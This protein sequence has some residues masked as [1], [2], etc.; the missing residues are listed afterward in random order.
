VAAVSPRVTCHI[1]TGSWAAMGQCLA[2]QQEAAQ[3]AAR[4]S[5]TRRDRRYVFMTL[6]GSSGSIVR[7]LHSGSLQR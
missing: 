7:R 5:I 2:L 1:V 6:G 3:V 4:V